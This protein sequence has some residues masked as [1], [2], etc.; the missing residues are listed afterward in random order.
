MD[1]SPSLT[2]GQRVY[3][4]RRRCWA[5]YMRPGAALG[6]GVATSIIQFDGAHQDA[7]VETTQLLPQG[8]P[9]AG[10]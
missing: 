3:H 4:I 7:V 2:P 8:H 1:L 6:L 10:P 5:T 9:E